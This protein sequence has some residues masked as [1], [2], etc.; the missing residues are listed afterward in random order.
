MPSNADCS[1]IYNSQDMKATKFLSVEEWIEK[2]WH[3]YTMEYYLAIKKNKTVSFAEMWIDIE[4]I[5]ENE[6][7]QKDKNKY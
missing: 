3:T 4:A 1:T 6:V 7:S 2:L 5:V